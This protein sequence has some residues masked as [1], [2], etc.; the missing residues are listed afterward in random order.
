LP[1]RQLAA[2]F[3]LTFA[4]TWGRGATLIFANTQLE[5][6]IGSMGPPIDHPWLYYLVECWDGPRR[7]HDGGVLVSELQPGVSRVIVGS[8]QHPLAIREPYRVRYWLAAPTNGTQGRSVRRLAAVRGYDGSEHSPR[9]PRAGWAK[10]DPSARP[11]LHRNP[12]GSCATETICYKFRSLGNSS[13][14]PRRYSQGR[15]G[16][17]R[18][19]K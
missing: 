10:F 8:Y 15:M 9:M 2:H 18:S 4:I 11:P 6:M 14:T 13:L 7:C 12:K 19:T 3:G 16:N 1:I 17:R 5:E